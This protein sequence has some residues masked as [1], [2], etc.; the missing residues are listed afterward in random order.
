MCRPAD[1]SSAS[2]TVDDMAKQT[3]GDGIVSLR[4]GGP[5]AGFEDFEHRLDA[6]LAAR[7]RALVLDMA[8]VDRLSSTTIA[9]LLWARRRCAAHAVE[10]ELDHSSRQCR[11]ALE[12]TGLLRLVSAATP[13]DAPRAFPPLGPRIAGDRRR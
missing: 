3:A 7:P 10:I 9:M 4:G 6:A 5:G 1:L 12:R 2:A 8:A 13:G 11:D